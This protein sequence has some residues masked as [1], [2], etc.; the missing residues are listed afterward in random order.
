LK[1]R[2]F[3][4]H[5]KSHKLNAASSRHR[6]CLSCGSAEEFAKSLGD[7]DDLS[8]YKAAHPRFVIPTPNGGG[9]LFVHS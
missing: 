2:G 6:F 4:P 7:A 9:I 5:R 3:E 8:G 1:E